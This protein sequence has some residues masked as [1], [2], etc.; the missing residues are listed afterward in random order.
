MSIF[1]ILVLSLFLGLIVGAGVDKSQILPIALVSAVILFI[2]RNKIG[3]TDTALQPDNDLQRGTAS[4]KNYYTWQESGQFTFK[5]ATKS[6]QGAIQQLL[7]K[8]TACSDV[9]SV[10]RE[11]IFQACLI[12]DNDNPYNNNAIRIDIDNRTV[13]FLNLDE[14]LKFRARLE[15]K[16]LSNQITLCRAI[17]I[18]G[19]EENDKTPSYNVWLDIDAFE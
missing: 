6:F 2:N 12:P 15:T 10:P 19:A 1:S 4:G 3:T 7:Q 5:V 14:A 13:G 11:H 9:N 18:E 8:N 16:G 17:V